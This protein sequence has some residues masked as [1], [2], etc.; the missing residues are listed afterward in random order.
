MNHLATKIENLNA[1][2]DFFRKNGFHVSELTE[3]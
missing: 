1:V 3:V 2:Y